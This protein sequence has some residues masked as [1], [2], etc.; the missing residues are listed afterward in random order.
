MIALVLI[1]SGVFAWLRY[2]R[3]PVYLDDPSIH[4]AGPPPDLTP[5]AGAFV[6][7]GGPSRRALTAA[8][9]DLASRGEVAFRSYLCQAAL[10]KIQDRR[11]HWLAQKRGAGVVREVLSAL[12]AALGVSATRAVWLLVGNNNVATWSLAI[13]NLSSFL[14]AQFY[15]QCVVL[16][17]PTNALGAVVSNAAAAVVGQ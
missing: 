8:M 5:A 1:G 2:G 15:T 9:L 4:M 6:V 13:P 7:S 17:A 14:A 11:R 12:R 16:D 3:D 10:H